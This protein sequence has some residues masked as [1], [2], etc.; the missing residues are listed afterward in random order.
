MGDCD[1]APKVLD[2]FPIGI[3]GSR[4]VIHFSGDAKNFEEILKSV[5]GFKI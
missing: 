5:S 1:D 2:V 3:K 4:T